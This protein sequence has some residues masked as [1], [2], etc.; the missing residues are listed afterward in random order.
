MCK[1]LIEPQLQK[2]EEDIKAKVNA[3]NSEMQ[4][5]HEKRISMEKQGP[6]LTEAF[7]H[8]YELALEELERFKECHINSIKNLGANIKD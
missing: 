1:T 4:Y 6:K 7:L 3:V 2:E 5:I 8:H